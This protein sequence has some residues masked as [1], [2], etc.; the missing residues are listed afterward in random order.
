VR[1]ASQRTVLWF[2]CSVA[3]YIALCV[4]LRSY[5]PSRLLCISQALFY[6]SLF[7]LVAIYNILIGAAGNPVPLRRDQHP[8]SF[9]FITGWAIA[10]A[11]CIALIGFGVTPSAAGSCL[12]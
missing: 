2:L 8:V 10:L 6:S 9:W 12:K 5:V 1:T 11:T 3:A 4:G 7:L